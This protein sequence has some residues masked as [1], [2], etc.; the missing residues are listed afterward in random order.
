MP[1]KFWLF[2]YLDV[3]GLNLK[4]SRG[5][6]KRRWFSLNARSNCGH[7]SYN[8]ERETPGLSHDLAG[9]PAAATCPL[10][11][12]TLSGPIKGQK[13]HCGRAPGG[14]EG[15]MMVRP[16]K[17]DHSGARREGEREG[18]KDH[19]HLLLLDLNCRPPAKI[20]LPSGARSLAKLRSTLIN[21]SRR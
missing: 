20:A 5:F 2:T 19:H 9:R 21:V 1:D 10:P 8:C 16:S 17:V 12:Q 18:G 13:V 3:A 4:R 11:C 7:T 6:N 15:M 14:W